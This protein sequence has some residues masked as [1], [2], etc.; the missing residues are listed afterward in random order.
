MLRASVLLASPTNLISRSVTAYLRLKPE[1]HC[2]KGDSKPRVQHVEIS[3]DASH[4]C[5]HSNPSG[6]MWFQSAQ[7]VVG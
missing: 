7:P 3:N 4:E 6:E 1:P 2:L 5:Q